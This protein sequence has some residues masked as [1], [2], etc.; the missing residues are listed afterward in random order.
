MKPITLDEVLPLP[1][2][3]RIRVV[4]A[5]WNSIAD[6]PQAVDLTDE[7]KA[8]LDRRLEALENDPGAG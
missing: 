5:I 2:P 7:Q 6:T 3:D 1:I 4:E 8:E